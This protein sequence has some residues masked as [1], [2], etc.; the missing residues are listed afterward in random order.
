MASETMRFC[1][2]LLGTL[3][4]LTV[5]GADAVA[6]AEAAEAAYA[7]VARVATLMSFHDAGSELSAIN[8]AGA[9]ELLRID[10]WT[11]E[12]LS[13]ARAV[14][15]ASGG[16][17]D[18]AIGARLQEW[19][20]LPHHPDA[21]PRPWSHRGDLSQL[22]LLGDDTIMVH[23]P[24]CL[25]LG[26]IAKGY[27]VDQ[28]IE[29]LASHGVTHA[30]VNAGGDLRVLGDAPEEIHIRNPQQAQHLLYLGTLA[31]GAMATSAPYFSR[32]TDG[33]DQRCALVHPHTGDALN[34]IASYTVLAPTCAL[35]D[36]LTKAL[37]VDAN[38]TAPY[39]SQFNATAILL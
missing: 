12:V 35:A 7:A 37:A 23:R 9:G 14:Y 34:R 31:D 38:P 2:P 21:P 29:A 16:A 30:V 39:F 4:E 10:S 24:L 15:E 6:A 5:H 27:A 32:T 3:V 20:M 28:A 11:Y 1:R 18:C 33:T 8:R 25:D 17:F 26:G 36:A 19:Q 13:L 22:E